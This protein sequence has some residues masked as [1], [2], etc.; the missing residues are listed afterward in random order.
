MIRIG[1]NELNK[2]LKENTVHPLNKQL[3][4]QNIEITVHYFCL[5]KFGNWHDYEKFYYISETKEIVSQNDSSWEEVVKKA[6][7]PESKVRI[8]AEI[9]QDLDIFDMNQELDELKPKFKLIKNDSIEINGHKLYRLQALIDFADVKAGDLG[10]YIEKK[11]NLS[12]NGNAWIYDNAR[13]FD[14]A[15]ISGNVRI[16]D[17]VCVYDNARISGNACIFD[18]VK[19]FGNA[20][21]S[22][23]ACIY[24]KAHIYG[25]A[26]VTGR[27]NIHNNAHVF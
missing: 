25:D 18:D 13:V 1:I 6:N 8:Y 5:P 21:I 17:D 4:C 3:V 2:L 19:I 26:H 24:E 9:N 23:K 15:H 22:G 27:A 11:D 7:N 16:F 20:Y 14:N 10:G 12:Y